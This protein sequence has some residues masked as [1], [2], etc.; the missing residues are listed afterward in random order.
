MIR[1]LHTIHPKGTKF[2]NSSSI[3]PEYEHLQCYSSK[4][5]DTFLN[6]MFIFS[7]SLSKSKIISLHSSTCYTLCGRNGGIV[8][9]YK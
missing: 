9:Y 5:G 1:I 2:G 7:L 3:V 8:W 6:H 4:Q